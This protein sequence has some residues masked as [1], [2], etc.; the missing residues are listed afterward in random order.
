MKAAAAS[1]R[2]PGI[3]DLV[4]NHQLT[5]AY[6]FRPNSRLSSSGSSR[7]RN[8]PGTSSAASATLQ[9]LGKPATRT[10]LRL[11]LR[12]ATKSLSA[13]SK[14]TS[15]PSSSVN[16]TNSVITTPQAKGRREPSRTASRQPTRVAQLV[17]GNK[18][19]R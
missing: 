15:E 6:T 2:Q 7:E 11:P 5:S 10:H 13:G 16:R 17:G 8:D 19:R 12:N 1:K 3:P 14:I 18:S 9:P 4:K